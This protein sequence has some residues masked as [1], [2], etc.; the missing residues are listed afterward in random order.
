M[1]GIG[2]PLRRLRR[3]VER[4][5][6]RGDRADEQADAERAHGLLLSEV[7]LD[8]RRF[9]ASRGSLEVRLLREAAAGD[10][11]RGELEDVRVVVLR[12][13]VVPLALDRDAI[14]RSFELPLQLKKVLVRLELGIALD[15]D[16]QSR[17][18][19]GEPRLRLLELL[20]GLRIVRDVCSAAGCAARGDLSDARACFGDLDERRLLEVRRALHGL[21]EIGD[22][23]EA[24]LVIVLNLRPLC[25]DGLVELD[26]VVAHSDEP[27]AD[28]DGEKDDDGSNDDTTEQ[29][30]AHGT[31]RTLDL[32]TLL[33]PRLLPLLL[34]GRRRRFPRLHPRRP[35]PAPPHR[36]TPALPAL[37]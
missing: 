9:A 6:A 19:A 25:V 10:D 24:A 1:R 4:E 16:E 23:I 7:E 33:R 5:R 27:E 35:Q 3:D 11:A 8:L 14:L 28:D 21:Y 36:G 26:D 34:R 32:S 37:P 22:Q 31:S 18:C 13:L 2:E 29:A 17:Q 30:T 12:L 20:H 15:D